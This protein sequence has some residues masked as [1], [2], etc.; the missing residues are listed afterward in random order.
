MASASIPRYALYGEQRP[1][2]WLGMVQF[3]WI[4]ERSTLHQ[5]DIAPHFH[6]GLVQVL[7]PTRGSGQVFVEGD[8]WQFQAP[9]L[10]LVPAGHVHGFR[11][12]PDI[13]GPV[14]TAAQAPLES[15][16]QVAAPELRALLRRPLVLP[17]PAQARDVDALLPLFKA[18]ARE[19]RL[20]RSGEVAAGTA[21]LLAVLVQVARLAQGTE[22]L[23]GALAVG[24]EPQGRSR[25]AAQLERYRSLVDAHFRERWPIE[26]YAGHLGVSAGQLSRLCRELLGHSALEVLN[27]RTL[28]EAERELVY[29]A[30]SIKQVAGVLGFDDEAYFGRFFRKHSGLT[31]TQFRA[32]AQQ[33]LAA[34]RQGAGLAS[35]QSDH[36]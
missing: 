24:T 22:G 18:I 20:H 14:V 1:P 16:A 12:T 15:L 31:P 2:G 5:F 29:S 19:T 17:L 30:L 26:R 21:L 33:Q 9:A 34:Q 35:A 13:D 4:T 8:R 36:P 32:A 27:A 25:K 11:F 6:E 10:I 23:E 28:Q 7:H 3:E